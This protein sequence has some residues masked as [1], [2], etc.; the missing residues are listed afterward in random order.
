MR[1]VVSI[2]TIHYTPDKWT[3]GLHLTNHQIEKEKHLNPTSMTLG[4]MLI[5]QGVSVFCLHGCITPFEVSWLKESYR[6][7]R[8]TT[9]KGSQ[10]YQLI[11]KKHNTSWWKKQLKTTQ[12]T[13]NFV[14]KTSALPRLVRCPT[15]LNARWLKW[16]CLGWPVPHLRLDFQCPSWWNS[17]Q[18]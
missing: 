1:G 11:W 12:T 15:V 17:A 14:P 8:P 9:S 5:F 6:P 10:A 13:P 7:V 2:G 3:A 16:G 4:S 18:K